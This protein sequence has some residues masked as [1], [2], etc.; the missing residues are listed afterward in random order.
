MKYADMY[1]GSLITEMLLHGFTSE[2]N[3]FFRSDPRSLFPDTSPWDENLWEYILSRSFYLLIKGEYEELENLVPPF[4]IMEENY[5]HLYLVE[6]IKIFGLIRMGRYDDAKTRLEHVNKLLDTCPPKTQTK[7]TIIQYTIRSFLNLEEGHVE[8]A[9]DLIQKTMN[10]LGNIHDDAVLISENF[11]NYWFAYLKNNAGLAN[12]YLGKYERAEEELEEVLE[13]LEGFDYSQIK[14]F[15][16]MNLAYTYQIT[17]NYRKA[18]K[19][20]ENAAE[21]ITILGNEGD[22]PFVLR[23]L[24]KANFELGNMDQAEEFYIKAYHQAKE[25]GSPKNVLERANDI[26]SFYCSQRMLEKAKHIFEEITNYY[27][28]LPEHN[29]LDYLYLLIKCRQSLYFDRFAKILE[30]K[31]EVSNMLAQGKFTDILHRLEARIA[32]ITIQLM[33]FRIT[34]SEEDIIELI[35]LVKDLINEAQQSHLIEIQ[36]R[37][38]ALL[39]N[40]YLE[41]NDFKNAHSVVQKMEELRN[42]VNSYRVENMIE[43]E[44]TRYKDFL[45]QRERE[46]STLSKYHSNFYLANLEEYISKV[47]KLVK[48]FT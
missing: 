4:P 20:L 7:L 6:M 10:H 16:W 35:S 46:I 34:A 29:K 27:F 14:F 38:E 30:I 9:L 8:E 23:E 24:G 47:S 3:S 37:G 33:E 28:G 42:E 2:M 19:N 31:D 43:E 15:A 5:V 44:V 11:E 21:A 13:L 1:Y 32:L 48:K 17:G 18:I 45:R 41:R 26:H 36:L 39:L 25:Y 22:L 40:L 12:I